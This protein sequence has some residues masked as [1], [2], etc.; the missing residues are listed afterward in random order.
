MK[1]ETNSLFW[2]QN[3]VM[4]ICSK[5]V[6]SKN[7]LNTIFHLQMIVEQ[8][9]FEQFTPTPKI[10]IKNKH[11]LLRA[12]FALYNYF[13]WLVNIFGDS[14]VNLF[15]ENVLNLVMSNLICQLKNDLCCW[16]LPLKMARWFRFRGD[17]VDFRFHKAT[18]N[19]FKYAWGERM[20][21]KLKNAK[22]VSTVDDSPLNTSRK[23]VMINCSKFVCSK[24]LL[25]TI[26]LLLD[27]IRA[28]IIFLVNW[29]TAVLNL[30][31]CRINWIRAIDI[32]WYIVNC[33]NC[34]PLNIQTVDTNIKTDI[35]FARIAINRQI[36]CFKNMYGRN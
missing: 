13:W 15:G 12:G 27:S 4:I 1:L 25:D 21:C 5:F 17:Y 26:L 24:N 19:F 35:N 7:L 3:W 36:F 16:Y 2:P 34:W 8:S 31:S 22:I 9:N 29:S 30:L 11:Y 23:R 14:N 20:K 18:K 32:N 10:I 33:S 28:I 6:C